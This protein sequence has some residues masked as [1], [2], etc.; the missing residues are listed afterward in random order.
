MV[1]CRS[2]TVTTSSY[3]LVSFPFH[4]LASRYLLLSVTITLRHVQ[5]KIRTRPKVHSRL[6]LYHFNINAS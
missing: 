4:F 2:K 3:I 5:I 6:G 1:P